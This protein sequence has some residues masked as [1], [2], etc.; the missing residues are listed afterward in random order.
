VIKTWEI[1][2]LLQL[3]KPH[4]VYQRLPRRKI[5]TRNIRIKLNAFIFSYPNTFQV[6][7]VC[8]LEYNNCLEITGYM[9]QKKNDVFSLNLP[10]FGECAALFGNHPYSVR[11]ADDQIVVLPL[12]WNLQASCPPCLKMNNRER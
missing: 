2:T 9:V 1:Y 7:E 4:Q 5:L 11:A 8:P 3:V 12:E 6:A 10:F